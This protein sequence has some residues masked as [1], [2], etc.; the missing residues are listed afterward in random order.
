M[1][2]HVVKSGETLFAIAQKFGVK[3]A[4]LIAVNGLDK[5]GTVK[6]GQTLKI[7]HG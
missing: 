4:M 2:T 3:P 6:P 1:R 5:T 7:P